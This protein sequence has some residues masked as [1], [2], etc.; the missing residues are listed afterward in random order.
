MKENLVE[1]TAADNRR[2]RKISGFFFFPQLLAADM[3]QIQIFF[4]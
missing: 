1:F 4:G 3:K 2:S